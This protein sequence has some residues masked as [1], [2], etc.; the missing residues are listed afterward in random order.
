MS[1]RAFALRS[2][3]LRTMRQ[4]RRRGSSESAIPF[5]DASMRQFKQDVDSMEAF[6]RVTDVNAEDPGLYRR[7][8]YHLVMNK[9]TVP[10]ALE[11]LNVDLCR[12]FTST[13]HEGVILARAIANGTAVSVDNRNRMIVARTSEFKLACN[14]HKMLNAWEISL[15]WNKR[16]FHAAAVSNKRHFLSMGINFNKM[17]PRS[18][19]AQ[20][21]KARSLGYNVFQPAL[22]RAK[23]TQLSRNAG[24]RDSLRSAIRAWHLFAT[25]MLNYKEHLSAPPRS[26]E[27]VL[28]WVT[29]FG[30]YGT[31]LNYLQY[32][33]NFC[34]I[35][36]LSIDWYDNSN[37]S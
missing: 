19:I 34:E 3:F 11:G 18:I 36:G 4:N 16:Y 24:S 2:K 32:L 12:S 6:V 25:S 33:K 13:V 26:S 22:D 30:Q 28:I 31:A 10:Q 8:A 5:G 14:S 1:E 37:I 17:P 21:A 27:H 9:F 23:F 20:M 29:C 15:H 7:I 35:E